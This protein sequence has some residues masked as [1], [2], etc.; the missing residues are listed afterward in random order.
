MSYVFGVCIN[1]L[2]EM[3]VGPCIVFSIPLFQL[4]CEHFHNGMSLIRYDHLSTSLTA[5]ENSNNKVS[6]KWD[7]AKSTITVPIQDTIEVGL[8]NSLIT[9]SV[10]K[11][12]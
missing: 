10:K 7:C 8:G 2:S 1:N 5:S 3:K 9:C 11:Q 4:Q 12:D 6:I